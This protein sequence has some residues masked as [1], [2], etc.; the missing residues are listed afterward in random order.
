MKL[1][2]VFVAGGIPKTTYVTRE[3][4]S[5][6]KRLQGALA[7]GHQII[8]LTGATKSGKTVL[9]R[10][11]FESRETLWIDSGQVSGAKEFWKL[12]AQK[13][14]IPGE[15]TISQSNDNKAG[16]RYIVF[17]EESNGE[18]AS[19]KFFNDPKI[20]VL[21]ACK[22]H[23]ICLVIDDFHYLDDDVQKSVIRNLKSEIFDGLDVIVIAVPR[24]AF[25]T[26]RNEKEMEGR[27]IHIEI[28]PWEL[29]E[30]EEISKKGFPVLKVI[31]PSD[32]QSEFAQEAFKS[33]IL[34]QRFCLKLCS[35]YEIFETLRNEKE[36]NP[37]D[38][39]QKNI[40]HS[41][42]I[43]YGFPTFKV[44]SDGPQSRTDRLP[45]RLKESDEKVDIYHALLRAIARTG[46]KSALPYDEI[47]EAMRQTVL[48]SD[49]PQKQQITNSLNYMSREANKKVQ[50]E[51]PLEW[52]DEV[53]YLTD[54][55]LMF[56]L[57]W[58]FSGNRH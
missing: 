35:E 5:L 50:G 38:H 30:L 11:V 6:E 28:P 12:A 15:Y 52:R 34:M 7:E 14:D 2:E 47:R 31:T 9:C 57:R 3:R 16:F 19:E 22:E 24:R 43:D 41:V 53:L 25:D 42:A 27:F 55:S 48:D 29:D 21:T 46:P 23:D 10:R 56:Y 26:I 32:L 33:P 36:I 39:V 1:R 17:S 49:M 58:A 44:L 40:Y 51:P 54:P 18:V 45:R 8:A 20:A 37:A 4:L 13:L